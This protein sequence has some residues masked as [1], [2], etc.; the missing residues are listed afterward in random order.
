[1]GRGLRP[2]LRGLVAVGECLLAIALVL[3]GWSAAAQTTTNVSATTT[4]PV[5][6]SEAN[7]EGWSFSASVNTYIVPE[8]DDYA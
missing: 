2:A 6:T 4:T 8:G 3:P 1:V 5:P 7:E